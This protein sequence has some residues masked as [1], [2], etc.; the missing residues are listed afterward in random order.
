MGNFV[1]VYTD[2]SCDGSHGKGGYAAIL[3][4][5]GFY[6][7]VV[8]TIENATINRLELTAVINALAA[9]KPHSSVILYTDSGYVEKAVNEGRLAAWSLNGWRRIRTLEPVKNADLWKKLLSILRDRKLDVKF[10]KVAAHAGN[11]LNERVDLL[12]RQ[13]VKAA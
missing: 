8:G 10:R 7:E 13:A 5:R 2:G 12:A 1:S 6:K 9:V 3:K 4:K 11:R